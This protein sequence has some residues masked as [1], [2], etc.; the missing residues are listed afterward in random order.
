[1]AEVSQVWLDRVKR[2]QQVAA[3]RLGVDVSEMLLPRDGSAGGSQ[4]AAP[5]QEAA[6]APE[7]EPAVAA[8]A[9]EVSAPAPA[10]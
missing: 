2:A 9:D 10:E 6:L 1:M 7:P 3:E 4:D 8:V 5:A